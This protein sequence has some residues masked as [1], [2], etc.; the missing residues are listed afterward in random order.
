MPKTEKKFCD[1]CQWRQRHI[2]GVC[3]VCHP[4][5]PSEKELEENGQQTLLDHPP[6]A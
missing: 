4:P 3:E 6:A 1:R 2:D 5:R